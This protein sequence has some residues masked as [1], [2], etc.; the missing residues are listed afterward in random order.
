MTINSDYNNKIWIT[1]ERQ[2]RSLELAQSFDC[3]IY[4]YERKHK[5][6]LVRYLYASINSIR[7]LLKEKPKIVFCQNPSI[8]LTFLLC[9]LKNVFNYFL[10]V[11]RHSNFMLSTPM[12]LKKKIFLNLSDLTIKLADVTIVTNEPLLNN[13]ILNNN[14]FG[15]VLQDRLPFLE[16]YKTLDVDLDK[17]KINFLFVTSFGKDEPIDEFMRAIKEV[18]TDYF[19]YITGNYK[20]HSKNLLIN[21]NNYKFTGFISDENYVSLMN[22]VDI[23]IVLTKHEFTLTC[24]AYEGISLCK[25]LILSDTIAIREYFRKGCV[26][27]K[28][29]DI[30]IRN[31]IY[32]CYNYYKKLQ[33]EICDFREVLTDEWYLKFSI[34]NKQIKER[35]TK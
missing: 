20:K 31:A 6:R 2:R 14:S 34:V 27:T 15:L 10:I 23:V 11:D 26:Y 7:V 5:Y 25:P 24:G 33:I 28:S 30:S 12:C 13:H 9:I 3:N 19:F 29:D 18:S 16:D 22:S 21:G 17:S 1:W 32:E 8:F 4:I 35:A